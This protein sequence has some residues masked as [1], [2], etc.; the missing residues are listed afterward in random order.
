MSNDFLST[1]SCFRSPLPGKVH[2]K[3]SGRR[4]SFGLKFTSIHSDPLADNTQSCATPN[5]ETVCHACKS[6]IQGKWTCDV[7]F[8]KIHLPT[9]GWIMKRLRHGPRTVHFY[10][11]AGRAGQNLL[12]EVIVSIFYQGIH[13]DIT[14][15]WSSMLKP[16]SSK[17]SQFI[18]ALTFPLYWLL[19]FWRSKAGLDDFSHSTVQFIFSTLTVWHSIAYLAR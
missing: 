9:H 12:I 16:R 11:F 2:K 3:F 6:G 14:T 19:T 5:K 18:H 13:Q 15:P 7:K 17:N 1:S 4:P 10:S 8:V